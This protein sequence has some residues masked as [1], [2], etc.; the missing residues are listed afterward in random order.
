MLLK[1]FK[2]CKLIGWLSNI[3]TS[4]KLALFAKRLDTPCVGQKNDTIGEKKQVKYSF[5]YGHFN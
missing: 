2:E 5:M 4:T 1:S 3:F